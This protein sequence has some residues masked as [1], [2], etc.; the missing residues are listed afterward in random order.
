MEYKLTSKG[1]WSKTFDFLEKNQNINM[2]MPRLISAGANAGT[3][4]LAQATPKDTGKAASMWRS[5][6]NINFGTTDI[7][8]INDD[9]NKGYNIITLLQYG[10]GT[11]TGGYVSPRDFINPVMRPVY[12]A[13]A[14]EL[15]EEV[16][17]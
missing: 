12:K 15:W 11:G 10:H 17:K 9:V 2:K 1:D 3:E 13:I 5:E 6:I 16:T 8:W 7:F 14:D 4:S